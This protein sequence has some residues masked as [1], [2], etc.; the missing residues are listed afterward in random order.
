ML[1]RIMY[2]MDGKLEQLVRTRKLIPH[3]ILNGERMIKGEFYYSAFYGK[4]FRVI[5]AE[6]DKSGTLTGAEV[7][8]NDGN[9]CWICTDL[10]PGEDYYLTMDKRN[11][12]DMDI[13]NSRKPFSGA[14]IRYWFFM[15]NITVLDS[16][17]AC[18]WPYVEQYNANSI[19]DKST[20][21]L[22]ADLVDGIYTRARI[23][24]VIKEHSDEEEYPIS[25]Y[26]EKLRR[27][28]RMIEKEKRK[29]RR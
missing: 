23:Y 13:V 14:E 28:D 10:N 22:S 3:K 26:W 6:Y 2:S 29:R 27:R 25:E 17:Y 1:T 9:I 24:R 8:Y 12:M 11:I 7:K 15:N 4:T 18:F 16:K 21:T 20:Y 5:S 19:D